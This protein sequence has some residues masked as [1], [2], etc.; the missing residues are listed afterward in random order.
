MLISFQDTIEKGGSELKIQLII[1]H[2]TLS[3]P[4]LPPRDLEG[5][6]SVLSPVTNCRVSNNKKYQNNKNI[7]NFSSSTRRAGGERRAILLSSFWTEAHLIAVIS[8]MSCDH[9]SAQDSEKPNC[10]IKYTVQTDS[11]NL[12][13]WLA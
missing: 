1:L 2:R 8:I 10:F 11:G 4:S 12:I 6:S 3:R 7:Y 5:G 13:T 9:A